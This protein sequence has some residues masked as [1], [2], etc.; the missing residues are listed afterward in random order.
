[1]RSLIDS[2]DTILVMAPTLPGRLD[3]LTSDTDRAQTKA[4]ERLRTVMDHLDEMGAQPRG[5]VGADRPMQAFED[6]VRE[7]A[8]DHLLIGLRAQ[9]RKGVAGEGAARSD[10]AALRHSDDRL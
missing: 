5:E 2:A 9:D 3:W 10:P 1:V 7:F 6:A 4:D 8:P